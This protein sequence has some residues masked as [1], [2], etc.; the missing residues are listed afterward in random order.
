MH[1]DG[2]DDGKVHCRRA[3]QCMVV[4]RPAESAAVKNAIVGYFGCAH[5][6]RSAVWSHKQV[7]TDVWAI[8]TS[9]SGSAG[10]RTEDGFEEELLQRYRW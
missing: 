7:N 6:R 10:E 1:I 9:K 5:P 4:E 8:A 3:K 2:P